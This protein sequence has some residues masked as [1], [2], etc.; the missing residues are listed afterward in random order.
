MQT[1]TVTARIDDCAGVLCISSRAVD[2]GSAARALQSRVLCG[3]SALTMEKW[4]A[5]KSSMHAQRS[6]AKNA[7][8]IMDFVGSEATLGDASVVLNRLVSD[9]VFG[10]DEYEQILSELKVLCAQPAG[11]LNL[12]RGDRS[13][14]ANLSQFDGHC[15]SAG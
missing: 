10:H 5:L 3:L 12:P 11:A 2:L 4:K 7:R 15:G 13:N 1:A 8:A 6:A 9:D 14:C